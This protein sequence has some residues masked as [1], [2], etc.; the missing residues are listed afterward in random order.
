M[1]TI[2][3]GDKNVIDGFVLNELNNVLYQLNNAYFYY[4]DGN[5]HEWDEEKYLHGFFKNYHAILGKIQNFNISSQ[6]YCDC[7]YNINKI[8]EK[9][10]D[11]C[12]INFYEDEPLNKCVNNILHCI[13]IY[14]YI[15][16]FLRP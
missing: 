8:Y 6:T 5:F 11:R 12:S 9:Y 3:S 1:N 7:I 10:L 15:L 13:Y 16:L 4:F 14:I 2:G